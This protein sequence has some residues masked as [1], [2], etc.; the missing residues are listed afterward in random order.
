MASKILSTRKI[1]EK[2]GRNTMRRTMGETK[3]PKGGVPALRESIARR[4]RP[5]T[6]GPGKTTKER[7]SFA[8]GAAR[9]KEKK[10][11]FSLY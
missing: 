5:S 6:A 1:A 3:V 11:T 9:S 8:K 7:K 2:R 4:K 10:S